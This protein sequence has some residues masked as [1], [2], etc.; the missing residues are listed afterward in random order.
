MNQ[1]HQAQLLHLNRENRATRNAAIVALAAFALE[2]RPAF[3]A[4]L[5]MDGEESS[6]YLDRWVNRWA[7]VYRLRKLILD[8]TG[9]SG[10]D[11]LT[12]PSV[13]HR[14]AESMRFLAEDFGAVTGTEGFSQA[15]EQSGLRKAALQEGSLQVVSEN[16]AISGEKPVTD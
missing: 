8:Q 4:F 16:P 14:M 10:G 13:Y 1:D 12:M 6:A 7:E 2:N 15:L 3:D 11:R 5:A 9:I